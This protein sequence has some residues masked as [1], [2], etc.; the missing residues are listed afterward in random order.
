MLMEKSF[1]FIHVS[2][3]AK[4]EMHRVCISLLK[5]MSYSCFKSPCLEPIFERKEIFIC[6]STVVNFVN[7][8]VMCRKWITIKF[9]VFRKCLEFFL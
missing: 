4:C 5:R 1:I 2:C 7:V 6:K 8:F 3:L 9:N